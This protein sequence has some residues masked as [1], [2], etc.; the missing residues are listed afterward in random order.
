MKELLTAFTG[1]TGNDTLGVPLLDSD[2]T[3]VVWES[4]ERHLDCIQD[5]DGFQLYTQTGSLT[6]GSVKL[7]IYRCAR[8][9]TSLESFHLHINKFIPGI[10]DIIYFPYII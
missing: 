6:K 1:E 8:G 2:K 7:P 5:P 9:S 4:Q 10:Y 3:W